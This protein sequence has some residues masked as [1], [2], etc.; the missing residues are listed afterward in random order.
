MER[1]LVL[2]RHGQSEWNLKKLFTGWRDPDLT[3]QGVEEAREAGRRLKDE[4][5]RFDVA[6]TSVL[7]RAQR[8]LA[9]IEGAP[10]GFNVSHA[11]EFNQHLLAFLAQ[12]PK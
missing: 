8:T 10:H 5:L 6:F 1:L 2:A 11:K 4:G 7:S 9:L 12:L 3:E